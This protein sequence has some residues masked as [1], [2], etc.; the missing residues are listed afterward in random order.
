VSEELESRVKEAM[1]VLGFE[2]KRPKERKK[3]LVVVCIIP[4]LLNPSMTEVAVGA[5][6]EADRLGLCLSVLQV[7]EKPGYQ[8]YNLKLLEHF[9]FDG[10]MFF[11]SSIE[12]EEF[13][14]RCPRKNIPIVV[15]GID[16]H[17][18]HVD[19]IQTDREGGMYQATKYLFSLNHTKIAFL[20]GP[21]EWDLSKARLHGIQ[22]A[23]EESGIQFQ[24][25]YHRWGFPTIDWGF[26][27]TNSLLRLP[28]N[29]RPTAILAFNDLM[30]IG[31]LQAT[32]NAGV[33]VP[34]DISVV[35]FDNISLT[36]HTNPPLTTVSQ[37]KYQIGQL[38][39][40]KIYNRLEGY[41]T[42]PGGFTLLECPLVVREST[43]PCP[44]IRGAL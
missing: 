9:P 1:E 42:E 15:H 5:Q 36:A 11:H 28:D 10:V 29:E 3:P 22:R 43:G 34:E 14:Q 33:H 13:L 35:G 4:Q 23:F 32:R 2:P 27:M 12:P 30:A 31:A 25:H 41:E 17:S 8:S 19:C 18:P 26:Q 39:I 6:E 20:S 37:P 16:I 40:Q 7:T 38:S 44:D 24:T 21:P